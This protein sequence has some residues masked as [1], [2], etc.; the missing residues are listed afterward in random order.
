[1]PYL[2]E[3]PV[4][5]KYEGLK[6]LLLRTFGLSCLERAARILHMGGLGDRKPSVLMSEIL[7]LMDGHWPCLFFE[8]AF[9]EQLLDDICLLLSGVSFDEPLQL[10]ERTDKLWLAKRQGGDSLDPV[11]TAP[12]KAQR[13]NAART[14]GSAESL[15]PGEAGKKS[16]FYQQRWCSAARQS[17]TPC[18]LSTRGTNPWL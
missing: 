5:Q 18:S 17:R 9:L 12:W 15:A 8:Y 4:P 6:V 13:P 14:V 2:R 3:Q 16:C 1:M 11:S 10:A 7:T